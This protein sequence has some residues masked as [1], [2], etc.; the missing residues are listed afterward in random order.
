[1]ATK[2]RKT[3]RKLCT[4]TF[5]SAKESPLTTNHSTSQKSALEDNPRQICVSVATGI[6]TTWLSLFFSYFPHDEQ[7]LSKTFLLQ[8]T[9]LSLYY[10][11]ST[12]IRHGI[13]STQTRLHIIHIVNLY[14]EASYTNDS[15]FVVVAMQRIGLNAIQ[16][17]SRKVT[18]LC[19]FKVKKISL[20]VV[21]CHLNAITR[22]QKEAWA[23]TIETQSTILNQQLSRSIPRPKFN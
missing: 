20:D 14:L 5:S 6:Q 3:S 17:E 16:I 18:P 22:T 2:G 15:C 21:Q 13:I 11:T 9:H 10:T 1:M 23:Q 12:T 4:A 7:T 19:T 8:C